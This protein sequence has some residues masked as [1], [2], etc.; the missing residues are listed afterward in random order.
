MVDICVL[1]SLH[2]SILSLGSADHGKDVGPSRLR[3][4]VHQIFVGEPASWSRSCACVP[5]WRVSASFALVCWLAWWGWLELLLLL[6]PG[7][8]WDTLTKLAV[9]IIVSW[10]G[11][12][13]LIGR[14]GLW[15]LIT[16]F[17]FCFEVILEFRLLLA[18]LV[19][20]FEVWTRTKALIWVVEGSSGRWWKLL[21]W[22]TLKRSFFLPEA[23]FLR[24]IRTLLERLHWL[25]LSCLTVRKGTTQIWRV[26]WLIAL[27]LGGSGFN[28]LPV[29]GSVRGWGLCLLLIFKHLIE[30]V[31][32]LSLLRGGDLLWL[33]GWARWGERV[34]VAKSRWRCLTGPSVVYEVV[35]GDHV[36]DKHGRFLIAVL[37]LLAHQDRIFPICN[38]FAAINKLKFKIKLS[39]S[40]IYYLIQ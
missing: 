3:Q 2:Y 40:I 26:I 12:L 7:V 9:T 10:P 1:W 5:S 31:S 23:H 30:P 15:R 22:S 14:L 38:L 17:G 29:I 21:L 28:N 19:A 32:G 4:A 35:L 18:G 36:A 6:W 39:L 27:S 13:L 33:G 37:R 20:R 8:L 11:W 25:L 34:G 16:W 24:F